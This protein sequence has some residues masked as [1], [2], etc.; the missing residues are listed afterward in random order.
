MIIFSPIFI[1]AGIAIIIEDGF[2]VFFTQKRVG[3]NYYFFNS[4]DGRLLF[5]SRWHVM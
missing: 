3:I 1:F 2:P 5:V 4:I